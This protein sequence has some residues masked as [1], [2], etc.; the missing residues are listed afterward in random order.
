VVAGTVGYVATH[1]T[2]A[3]SLSPSTVAAGDTVLVT[4]THVPANQS[5]EI[6]LHSAVYIFPFRADSSG[7]VN[8]QITIPQ[9]SGVGD[10][11]VEICWASLCHASAILHVLAATALVSPSPATSP[12]PTPSPTPTPKPMAALVSISAAGSFSVRLQYFSVGTPAKLVVFQKNVPHSAGNVSVTSSDFR[13]TV[14]TPPGISAGLTAFVVACDDVNGPCYSS[15]P[16]SV[17]P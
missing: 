17:Q 9:I 12:L 10:H 13:T 2:V 16:V 14:H 8:A 3:I 15:P 4:A 5:G 6:R 11:I 7:N 1:S